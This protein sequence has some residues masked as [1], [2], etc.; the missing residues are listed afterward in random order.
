[1]ESV[2]YKAYRIKTEQEF[3]NEGRW[4]DIFKC[5]VLWSIHMNMYLG[6]ILNEELNI[7]CF[8]F[9]KFSIKEHFIKENG[10]KDYHIWTFNE[11]DY[12]RLEDKYENDILTHLNDG[13][14]KNNYYLQIQN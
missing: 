13:I 2:R 9:S 14:K 10:I 12:I 8:E 11:K 4:S 6:Q 1:M 3:K 5:P 7:N